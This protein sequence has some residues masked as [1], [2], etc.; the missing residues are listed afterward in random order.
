M[1]PALR[2]VGGLHP[3][4]R[5]VANRHSNPRCK[6]A[7]AC[8]STRSSYETRPSLSHGQATAMPV[9]PALLLGA[10]AAWLSVIVVPCDFDGS[11]CCYTHT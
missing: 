6:S 3:N 2:G 4:L 10:K 1:R 5:T 7:S 8:C 11:L 9:K